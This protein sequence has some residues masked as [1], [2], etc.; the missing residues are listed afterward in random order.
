M[1]NFVP[2]TLLGHKAVDVHVHDH[3]HVDVHVHD[4]DHVN[5]N[6]H[7]HEHVDVAVIV[8]VAGLQQLSLE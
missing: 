3:E 6:V 8:D 2:M 7:D 1:A 4:H 5:V